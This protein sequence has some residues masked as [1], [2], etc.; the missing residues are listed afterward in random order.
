MGILTLMY[1]S[2]CT[3]LDSYSLVD[4]PQNLNNLTNVTAINLTPLG[5]IEF[6]SDKSGGKLQVSV[7]N[8]GLAGNHQSKMTTGGLSQ[9]MFY[10]Q[11]SLFSAAL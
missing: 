6:S 11:S 8:Y 1:M 3:N 5:G 4:S 2:M 10:V 9:D 7:E